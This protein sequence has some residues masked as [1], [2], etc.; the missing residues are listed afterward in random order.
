MRTV[1]MGDQ[2]QVH[3]VKRFQDGSVVS[4]RSRGEPLEVT[5][6]TEHPRLPGLGLALVGSAPGSRV[7]L[8]L[9]AEQAYGVS[10]PGRIR[11]LS[12]KRFPKHQAFPVGKWVRLPDVLGKRP[13]RILEV[14]EGVVIVDTNHPRAG[15]ALEMEIEL[16]SIH[17]LDVHQEP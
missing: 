5:V 4:S 6:G 14:R 1:Q 10:D 12:R 8:A 17:A 11:R 9:P 2:V 7:E 3:Y 16:I 15:Q 13:V